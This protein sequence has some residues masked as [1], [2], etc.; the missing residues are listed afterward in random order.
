ME[1]KMIIIG[2]V[3]VII[4]FLIVFLSLGFTGVWDPANLSGKKEESNESVV[5]PVS[6]PAPVP[7]KPPLVNIEYANYKCIRPIDKHTHKIRDNFHQIRYKDGQV[8]CM[9]DGNPPNNHCI[10]TL[11]EKQCNVLLDGYIRDPKSVEK[12]ITEWLIMPG[13]KEDTTAVSLAPLP[14]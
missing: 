3:V 9:T 13:T 14:T 8:Y 12:P 6:T 1:L 7:T 2:F 4:I 11:D 5:V 10:Q